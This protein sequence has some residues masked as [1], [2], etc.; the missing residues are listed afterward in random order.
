M[1]RRRCA[2]LPEFAWVSA[3]SSVPLAGAV[4]APAIA[5]LVRPADSL[6]GPSCSA[7]HTLAIMRDPTSLLPAEEIAHRA[8]LG[9][10]P[11]TAGERTSRP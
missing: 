8:G 6:T 7:V 9:G 10:A 1:E 5:A 11:T 3:P 2:G 4:V